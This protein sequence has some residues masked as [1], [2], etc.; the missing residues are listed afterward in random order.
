M[1]ACSI[2]ICPSRIHIGGHQHIHSYGNIDPFEVCEHSGD[3]DHF[4]PHNFYALQAFVASGG[5]GP[6]EVDGD[7]NADSRNNHTDVLRVDRKQ[8][9]QQ[10]K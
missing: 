10:Q 6:K 4:C 3:M 9:R 5:F 7:F 8:Q 2:N 1:T